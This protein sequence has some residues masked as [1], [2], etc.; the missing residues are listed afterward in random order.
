MG[1][2]HAHSQHQPFNP[3]HEKR[4]GPYVLRVGVEIG[5]FPGPWRVYPSNYGKCG[6]GPQPFIAPPLPARVAL[7]PP[8]DGYFCHAELATGR[9]FE[10][11]SPAD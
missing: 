4:N 7:H 6:A 10:D 3:T 8:T 9:L 11:L 5:A 2:P 1:C